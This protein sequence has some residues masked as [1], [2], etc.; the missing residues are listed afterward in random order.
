MQPHRSRTEPAVLF[1]RTRFGVADPAQATD[2][3]L[4]VEYV[5]GVVA[6]VNGVEAGRGH[7]PEGTIEPCTP[8]AEYAMEVYTAKDASREKPTLDGE[9]E[10]AFMPLPSVRRG[11]SPDPKLLPEYRE[12][13][14]TLTVTVPARALVK[15]SNVL[16]LEIHRAPVLRDAP[17]FQ[18]R[19]TWCHLGLGQVAISGVSGRGAISCGEALKHTR[20]WSAQAV[21]QVTS[22]PVQPRWLD[23]GQEGITS[24]GAMCTGLHMGNPFDPLLPVRILVPRNG[25]GNGQ[26]V[27]TDPNGLKN[28]TAGLTELRGAGNA[29]IKSDGVRIRYGRQNLLHWC[30]ELTDTPPDGVRTMP[31]WVEV[32]APKNQAP[33]WYTGTVSLQA[34]GQRFEVAVQVFVTGFTAPDPRDFR[35]IM[36]AMHSPEATAKTY[37]LKPY[38][39]EHFRMMGKSLAIAGQL[40][41]DMMFVPV[42]VGTHMHHATGMIRWVKTGAG[43]KPDYTLFEK[44]LDLYMKHCGPPKGVS[45]YV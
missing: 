36:V 16:A 14:R 34:N 29:T 39:A 9:I 30:D 19:F 8:A 11:Q 4:S 38:S 12:R 45:L 25:I 13:V 24:R 26:V 33:G 37:N 5:G 18:R 31:V 3:K 20:V 44:Y 28:V 40:G 23:R 15:G 32:S 35:S 2:L 41:A 42:Q 22:E 1:L 43:L 27:L 17:L 10:P 7:M 21:E 6:Y